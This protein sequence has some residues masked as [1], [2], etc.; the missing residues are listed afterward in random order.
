MQSIVEQLVAAIKD[1]CRKILFKQCK[2]KMI[3]SP[4]SKVEMAPLVSCKAKEVLYEG[5]VKNDNERS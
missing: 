2:L 3:I 4:F 1:D 5:D